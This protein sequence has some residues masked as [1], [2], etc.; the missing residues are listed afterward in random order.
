MEQVASIQ[1]FYSTFRDLS[2]SI[3]SSTRVEEVLHLAVRKT[4]EALRAKGSILRILNLKSG[5]LELNA[6][7]GLS[8]RYLS[9]GHVS[10]SKVIQ[11]ICEENRAIIVEDVQTDPRVQY[12]R[13]AKEEGIKTMLD[14]PLFVGQNV[15]GVLRIFFDHQRGF[16]E[17]ELDFAVAIAEQC[18]LA[19]DKAR[20]I[21]KQQIQYDHLAMQADKLS[22]LGRMA[23][24]IA[25]EINNPLA[26]ILLYSSNLVKKVPE[27]GPLK[28]GL[29]VIIHE[30]IRCRGIIQDLLEFSR[31]R[32]PVRTPADLNGVI[33]KALSI[34]A[35]EF[36]L[37]RISLEK[38][39]SDDLPRV[40]IDVNQVEQVFINF[41]INAVEAIQGQGSVSVRSYR[42]D[43]GQGAVVEIED[44]G[45]GIPQEHLE[46]IFE[47]FFSTKPKGTGLGLAVNYGI[48]QKHG[49]QIKVSSQPGRGTTMTV[50]LPCDPAKV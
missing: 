12:P 33:N 23:A 30:T 29:E 15:V 40:L 28:K 48:I 38:R 37:N 36:R 32:E 20:L 49:G 16:S 27:T 1:A 42:D 24:G 22:S 10:S 46:R 47:P 39:L 17:E 9:K 6:A 35:N 45:M 2:K 26:G 14:L 18:A 41:L 25:H 21:E 8:E 19:I 34:L 50:R 43:D 11:E 4:T 31:Q 44:S 7:Y 5:E 3:H 13:E